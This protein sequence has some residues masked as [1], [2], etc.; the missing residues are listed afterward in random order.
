MADSK[1]AMAVTIYDATTELY[2]EAFAVLCS[3]CR[4]GSMCCF[5]TYQDRTHANALL[6]NEL[7]NALCGG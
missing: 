4:R 6:Y 2:K 1:G 5:S 7:P 3:E